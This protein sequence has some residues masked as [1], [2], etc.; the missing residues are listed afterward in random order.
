MKINIKNHFAWIIAFICLSLFSFNF[1]LFYPG[2]LSVDWGGYLL[3]SLES[4]FSNW[5]P[6]I[7][8]FSLLKLSNIFG[9]HIWYSLL[10]NLIPF[11]LGVYTLVLSFWKK[12]H[13]QWC[14]LGLLPICVGNIFFNNII[15]HGSFSSPM[16]IFLLWTIVLYQI[17][18]DINLKNTII[19]CIAFIF[20]TISR[21]NALIQVYPIFF[22][23]S[24]IIVQKS[25]PSHKLLKYISWCFLFA[26]LTLA[27]SIGIPSL[28]KEGR[29]YPSNHVFL[30][31]IAGACVPSNDESCFKPEWYEEG[32]S[33]D[34]VKLEYQAY[35]LLADKMTWK[36][37][38][39]HP[40]RAGKLDDLS[41]LWLHSIIKHPSSY[42]KYVGSFIV[43]MWHAN[44]LDA[45]ISFKE[46]N[47]CIRS[48]DCI[49]LVDKYLSNE[50]FYET[51]VQK[52]QILNLLKEIFPQI[53]TLFYITLNYVLFIIS[54]VLFYKRRDFLLLYTLSSS[55]AGVA[56]SIIF[57]IFTPATLP[58]YIYPV[59]ISTLT[60]TISI[61][62]HFCT[63]TPILECNIEKTNFKE[64][65]KKNK[66]A[67]IVISI[68]II[69]YSVYAYI[70]TPLK[71]RADV[72]APYNDTPYFVVHQNNV[73][74]PAKEAA[75]MPKWGNR[76][77]VVQENGHKTT[78]SITAL[79]GAD[80]TIA[81]R[82]PDERNAAGK[83][84]EKWVEYTSFKINGK[85]AISSHKTV[86][87]DKPLIYILKAKKDKVYN[88]ELKWR[89]K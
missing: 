35:P 20:A 89:K 75:W 34:D 70:N 14:W 28:L 87:H 66:K 59:I 65:I 22:I 64:M 11:Y 83:R 88:I 48:S 67:L 6:V 15:M 36:S 18:V 19:T 60:S 54:G 33:F 21:H 23:Y 4:Y 62:L 61:V 85:P 57:C 46:K 79:Q 2:Y 86:W 68:L 30:H 24:W 73:P 40:F 13:S 29:S 78:F 52:V 1:W 39:K 26:G 37:V 76:G 50:I 5:H 82:G 81:L 38:E 31:Q 16:L 41:K 10:F 3:P 25:R 71:A 49:K 45:Q 7:Y 51:P 74:Q 53:P 63:K 84:I 44:S 32:R 27:V 69:L 72:Y 9:Y 56:G 12:F 47:R 55:I 42:I 80:I 58:R 8:P 77:V 17:L 43:Q